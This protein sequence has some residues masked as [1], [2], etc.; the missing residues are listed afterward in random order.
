VKNSTRYTILL[1][2]GLADLAVG[3]YAITLVILTSQNALEYTS[4]SAVG[5]LTLFTGLYLTYRV[6]PTLISLR[7]GKAAPI[8]RDERT[9]QVLHRAA[10]NAFIFLVA[11][12]PIVVAL[13]PGL[14]KL[15]VVLT[16][17]ELAAT[18]MIVW[19]VAVVTFYASIAYY[20]RT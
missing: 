8:L 14:S 19:I 15:G 3:I 13:P 17:T 20:N 16:C 9:V 1:F 4:M 11:V 18:T 5:F 10:R 6:L 12:L 2:A 7:R